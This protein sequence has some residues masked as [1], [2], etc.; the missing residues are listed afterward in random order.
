VSQVVL[1]SKDRLTGL[2]EALDRMPQIIKATMGVSTRGVLK[3]GGTNAK[4][5]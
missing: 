1:D 3:N 2:K 5:K 4:S